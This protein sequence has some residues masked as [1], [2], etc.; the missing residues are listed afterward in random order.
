M[1]QT[2][3]ADDK[4]LVLVADDDATHRRVLQEVLEAAGFQVAVAEDGEV[5]LDLF[6]ATQPD[7]VL[8][9]VEMPESLPDARTRKPLN[10][11]TASA[12]PIFSTSP[13]A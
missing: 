6:T 5:A 12:Q 10:A 4:P 7:A 9:D 1:D 3:E 2:A 11:P 13:S 8:L